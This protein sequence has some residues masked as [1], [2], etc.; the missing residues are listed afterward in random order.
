MTGGST[1]GTF[2]ILFTSAPISARSI[3]PKAPATARVKSKILIP[4]RIFLLVINPEKALK[5][6]Q[7]R[8][9]LIP[10]ERLSFLRQVHRNY[11]N[12]SDEKRFLKIDATKKKEEIVQLC[13]KDILS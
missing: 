7:D 12:L 13:C 4:D 8:K 11:L 6:I 10:F 9:K 3:D 5:R 2:S 1:S